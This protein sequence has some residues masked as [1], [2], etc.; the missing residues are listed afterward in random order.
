MSHAVQ[1]L[2]ACVIPLWA[3]AGGPPV[4]V[5]LLAAFVIGSA[6]VFA[7]AAAFR[8]VAS[9]V[10]PED[11]V[12]GQSALS[13]AWSVGFFAGPAAAGAL[14][15]LIGPAYALSAEAGA[16]LLATL[17]MLAVRARPAVEP[18]ATDQIS[19][20]LREG[21]RFI[22]RD[23]SARAYTLISLVFSF[24][25][26]G[27]YALQIPLLRDTIGLSPG[28]T[29]A[30][31]AGGAIAGTLAS[32]STARL[33]RRFGAASLCATGLMLTPLAIAGLA[34]AQAAGTALVA[35]CVQTALAWGLSTLFISARQRRAP[36]E[37]QA[38]VGIS[39]RMLLLG[40][41]TAGAALASAATGALSVRGTYLAMAGAAALVALVGVPT[42]IRQHRRTA[43]P[44]EPD[45]MIPDLRA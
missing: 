38:R 15:G 30:V 13:A 27:T 10:G 17:L 9:V 26:A 41:V 24:T 29:G 8:A 36:A 33:D 14:V 18:T 19:V 39:G 1:T 32:L 42:L 21:L 12:R 43:P 20:G 31:L 2:A 45:G 23:R 37:L 44:E 22:A 7:D 11:F 28:L 25:I 34:F 4:G 40:S 3:F 35:F 16:F 6:R 5:A